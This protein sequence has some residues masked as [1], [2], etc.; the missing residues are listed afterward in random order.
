MK[1]QFQLLSRRIC[2]CAALICVSNT[3]LTLRAQTAG[4]LDATFAPDVTGQYVL[5]TAMQPDGKILLVGYFSRVNEEP[6]GNIAA[7]TPTEHWRAQQLSTPAPARRVASEWRGLKNSWLGTT[8]KLETTSARMG[9]L[10]T[11]WPGSTRA[12]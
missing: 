8:R 7:S 9:F 10:I 1:T 11:T 2:L 5:A 6:R 4:A 12:A 3:A